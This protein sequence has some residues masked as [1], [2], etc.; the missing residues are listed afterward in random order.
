MAYESAIDNEDAPDIYIFKKIKSF[1]PLE[2]AGKIKEGKQYLAVIQEYECY[3]P[4]RE[5]LSIHGKD[6]LE[7]A[8][9]EIAEDFDPEEVEIYEIEN[10]NYRVSSKISLEERK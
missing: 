1:G 10:V 9:V 6:S 4:L 2:A 5:G 8:L 7:E 3:P